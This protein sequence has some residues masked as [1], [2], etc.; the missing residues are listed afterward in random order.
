MYLVARST[1]AWIET[2]VT[3]DSYLDY[4]VARSTRAWIE[5]KFDLSNGQG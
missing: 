4:F 1:R 5:T 3:Y 2:F